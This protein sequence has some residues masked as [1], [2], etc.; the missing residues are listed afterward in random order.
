MPVSAIPFKSAVIK[1]IDD[2]ETVD[3]INSFKMGNMAITPEVRLYL[4]KKGYGRGFYVA[5]FYRYSV[6]TTNEVPVK[7]NSDDGEQNTVNISGKI[8][9][10]SV[11]MLLGVQKAIGKHITLDWWLLGPQYGKSSANLEGVTGKALSANEQSSLQ[12]NLEDIN[13]PRIRTKA[14]VTANNVGLNIEGPWAGVRMGLNIG[15]RF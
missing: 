6:F 1:Y 13:I 2:P 8:T 9:A 11:G 4:S 7:Y 15:V 12:S 10:N 14:T 3:Q 5:P